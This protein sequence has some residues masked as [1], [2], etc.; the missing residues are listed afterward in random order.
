[1]NNLSELQELPQWVVRRADKIPLRA[2][3]LERASIN[4]PEDWATYDEALART[5]QNPELGLGFVITPTCPF[6][7]IDLDDAKSDP[8]AIA[9]QNTIYHKFNSYTELSPSGKGVHII[10]RGKVPTNK[11]RSKV[12]VYSHSRYM[13]MTFNP[14][15]GRNIPISDEQ[16]L[17]T[18]LWNDMGGYE[19][20]QEEIQGDEPETKTDEQII[21]Q[22]S[23]ATNGSL[24]LQLWEGNW[25][26]KY[27]NDHSRADLALINIIAFYTDNK[28]QAVRIFRASALG[29]RPKAKRDDYFYNPKWGIAVKAF[30]QKGRDLSVEQMVAAAAADIKQQVEAKKASPKVDEYPLDFPPGIIGEIA[31]YIYAN[32]FKPNKEIAIGG[33]LAYFAGLVGRSY[34]YSRSGL[35]QY[36]IVLAGTGYGKDAAGKGMDNINRAIYESDNTSKQII[37]F[38]GPGN[39]SSGQALYKYI[40]EQ[41]C[42]VSHIKE[43]GHWM[44]RICDKRANSSDKTMRQAMLD[45]FDASAHGTSVKSTI[46]A[47]SAKNTV[48]VDSPCFTVFGD[49]TPSAFYKA[50]DEDNVAEGLVSRLTI[51]E[52]PEEYPT[53]NKNGNT[54]PVPLRLIEELKRY[55]Q[56]V[57]QMDGTGM[58]KYIAQTPEAEAYNDILQKKYDD[59]IKND[60]DNPLVQIWNRA[61][62]RGLRIAGLLA[63]GESK[64]NP[65]VTIEHLKWA[66]NLI[67]KSI[68]AVADKFESGK[69]G[70]INYQND[71]RRLM[72]NQLL[73]YSR[74]EFNE[75]LE[76]SYGL[77]KEM[78]KARV[79]TYRYLSGKLLSCSAFK[80]DKNANLAFKT[81]LDTYIK[82]G[83]LEKVDLIKFKPDARGGD[84]YRIKD[85]G[86]LD[87]KA[88]K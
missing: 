39:I 61:H 60:N 12:E 34:N 48:P 71:Q 9:D 86:G 19:S 4:V 69:I 49:S 63:V 47:E 42:F 36:I 44:Q 75:A 58:V 43:I 1:M 84:A 3:N 11:K 25:Q 85:L 38:V 23:T 80:N 17:L 40:V 68:D 21:E 13:T 88:L 24:F 65:T 28:P 73:K 78:I 37:R 15:E 55:L 72:A 51:I 57:L 46:F 67:T 53:Y 22:A 29:K 82:M 41:P 52:C 2:A 8:I 45:L 20:S 31:R 56:I 5:K 26:D 81:M 7:F 16:E 62:F 76:K 79:I 30:D 83:H 35:N 18:Q 50:L 77:T 87:S 70:D 32:A 66:E 6:S 14:V 54:L 33:A 27:D 59:M 64:D 74:L 10:V